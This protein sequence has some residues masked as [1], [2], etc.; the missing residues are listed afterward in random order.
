[1]IIFLIQSHSRS[2][3]S[4]WSIRSQPSIGW[5]GSN[6]P[7]SPTKR[8][9]LDYSH[10]GFSIYLIKNLILSGDEHTHNM[11]CKFKT[12]GHTWVWRRLQCGR[13]MP[14]WTWKPTTWIKDRETSMLN[15]SSGACHDIY[16]SWTSTYL[17]LRT[18]QL[19]FPHDLTL[20]C[21]WVRGWKMRHGSIIG[22]WIWRFAC[23]YLV[24][25]SHCLKIALIVSL[26]SKFW[27]GGQI[28][29]RS[30]CLSLEG[31]QS[32]IINRNREIICQV[33]PIYFRFFLFVLR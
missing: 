21:L 33:Q 3:R 4:F 1:M 29:E 10:L 30:G 16:N 32:R 6:S 26:W 15:Q 12:S 14:W 24:Q 19:I 8:R 2:D 31:L 23:F 22:D 27:K 18:H 11:M 17:L 5:S 28:D 7:C 20:P 13:V 9:I 25:N